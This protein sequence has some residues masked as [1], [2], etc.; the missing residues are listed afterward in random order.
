M[1]GYGIRD[2]ELYKELKIDYN[3]VMLWEVKLY[4]IFIDRRYQSGPYANGLKHTWELIKMLCK[5]KDKFKIRRK[6]L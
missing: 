6:K 5:L 1:S 4:S 2:V 3:G